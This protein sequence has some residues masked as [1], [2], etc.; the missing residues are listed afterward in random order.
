M[1]RE[2][3]NNYKCFSPEKHNKLRTNTVVSIIPYRDLAILKFPLENRMCYKMSSQDS[4]WKSWVGFV[5]HDLDFPAYLGFWLSIRGGNWKLRMSSLKQMA[6]IFL[7]LA[8]DRTIYLHLVPYHLAEMVRCPSSVLQHLKDG[9]FVASFIGNKSK[10]V[11]MDE[12][13]EMGINRETK[14]LL[15]RTDS[16][17]I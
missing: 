5:L 6:P 15:H 17:Y 4:T 14:P 11:A 2:E 1:W 10:Q 16:L 7:A 13:L 8:L 9:G 3:I 12:A